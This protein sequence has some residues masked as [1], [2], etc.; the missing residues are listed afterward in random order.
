MS[1]ILLWLSEPIRTFDDDLALT[2]YSN[3][4]NTSRRVSKYLTPGSRTFFGSLL[5]TLATK[6]EITAL[7]QVKTVSEGLDGYLKC[8]RMLLVTSRTAVEVEV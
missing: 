8:L 2:L 7:I 5:R 1:I 4:P 6:R 3:E